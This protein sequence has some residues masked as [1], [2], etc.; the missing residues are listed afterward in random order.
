M[1]IILI[2]IFYI[3][4]VV[5]GSLE[6]GMEVEKIVQKIKSK[7]F[8]FIFFNFLQGCAGI[9]IVIIGMMGLCRYYA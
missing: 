3:L 9:T 6:F 4:M 1:P 7:D 2:K 8:R 5:L